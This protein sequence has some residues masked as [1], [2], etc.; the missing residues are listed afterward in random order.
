MQAHV[1]RLTLTR[2]STTGKKQWITWLCFVL[3][4]YHVKSVAVFLV[5]CKHVGLLWLRLRETS[6]LSCV[7][8]P[9]MEKMIRPGQKKERQCTPRTTRCWVSLWVST[10][11]WS[12]SCDTFKNRFLKMSR[13]WMQNHV[14]PAMDF[15][16]TPPGMLALDNMLY[17]AKVHQD[18]YIR[19]SLSIRHS[20]HRGREVSHT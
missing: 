14:N 18:T 20:A 6:S 5:C 2:K 19:V 1:A 10:T 15:T 16:Q 9:S 7:G 11:D 17:L 3:Y 12:F 4:C 8:L 13:L